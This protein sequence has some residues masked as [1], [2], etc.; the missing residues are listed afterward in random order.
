MIKR[1]FSIGIAVTAA[2][3]LATWSAPRAHAQSTTAPSDV[4]AFTGNAVISADNTGTPPCGDPV[5]S[6]GPE[7]PHVDLLGGCGTFTFGSIACAGVSD[8]EVTPLIVEAGTCT[9]TANGSFT[10]TACGTGSV[11]GGTASVA[12]FESGTIPF[13]ITFAAG[14][15][16]VTGGPFA[17]GAPPAGDPVEPNDAT[18][19]GVVSLGPG[20]TGPLPD[21][22][23]DCT[24]GFQVTGVVVAQE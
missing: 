3:A 9:I 1:L 21:G 10:N 24:N 17:E 18:V 7:T 14:I 23:P 19:T 22:P 11:T 20:G 4:I 6:L 16:L 2:M 15:G 5:D 13:G 8:P 12:G